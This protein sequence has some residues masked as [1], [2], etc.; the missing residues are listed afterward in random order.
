MSEQIHW[1]ETRE[2]D[3]FSVSN[4]VWFTFWKASVIWVAHIK[5]KKWFWTKIRNWNQFHF[6]FYKYFSL[7]RGTILWY[8]EKILC[9]CAVNLKK[10][11]N[12]FSYNLLKLFFNRSC[13]GWLL[14]YLSLKIK[15]KKNIKAFK[16][17]FYYVFSRYI[18]QE[19]LHENSSW[20]ITFWTF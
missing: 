6:F 16:K 8:S 1:A 13:C 9:I 14:I 19:K 10:I 11:I 2:F 12:S 3:S 18:L 7:T 20:F 4:S 15:E 17:Y 5:K